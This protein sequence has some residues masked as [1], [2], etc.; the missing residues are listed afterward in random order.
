MKKVEKNIFLISGLG[1]GLGLIINGAIISDW[2]SYV[3]YTIDR[4]WEFRISIRIGKEFE[5]FEEDGK[6]EGFDE[7]NQFDGNYFSN[8]WSDDCNLLHC[9]RKRAKL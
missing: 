2:A 3:S 9:E 6:E 4:A 8:D 7:R 5:E 1:I